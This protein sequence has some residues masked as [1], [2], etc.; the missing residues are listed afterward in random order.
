MHAYS[1]QCPHE[2]QPA[3]PDTVTAK[4]NRR[5]HQFSLKMMLMLVT[6]ACV[7]TMLGVRTFGL[8]QRAREHD[9][10]IRHYASLRLT[11]LSRR[12][13]GQENAKGLALLAYHARMAN[14]CRSAVWQPWIR[15]DERPPPEPEAW[16]ATP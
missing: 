3:E 16:D 7:A 2:V 10:Q 8:L 6:L 1:K 14:T 9:S 12:G 15:T 5:W 13:D 11:E 4:T